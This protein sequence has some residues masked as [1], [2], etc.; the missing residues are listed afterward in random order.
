MRIRRIGIAAIAIAAWA[1]DLDVADLNRRLDLGPHADTSFAPSTP[2]PHP[3]QPS[4]VDDAKA[5]A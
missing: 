4:A 5:E 3:Q 1:K 2:I